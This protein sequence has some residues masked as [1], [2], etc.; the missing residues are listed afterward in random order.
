MLLGISHSSVEQGSSGLGPE[1]MEQVGQV[2][3]VDDQVPTPR[4]P[5]EGLTHLPRKPAGDPKQA[6][7][8]GAQVMPFR[9][10][11]C[12]APTPPRQFCHPRHEDGNIYSAGCVDDVERC[13]WKS[14]C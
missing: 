6:A 1:S 10:T 12:T 8:A 5:R 14:R 4:S 7:G 2:N 9:M 11:L 3:Q 13:I